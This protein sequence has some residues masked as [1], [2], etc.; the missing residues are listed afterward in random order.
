M[1]KDGIPVLFDEIEIGDKLVLRTLLN[2]CLY[3]SQ[4]KILSLD[5]IGEGKPLAKVTGTIIEPL[6]SPWKEKLMEILCTRP[7]S[8]ARD[9]SVGNTALLSD[10]D[11]DVLQVG[12]MVDA[13]CTKT[14]K[15]FEAKIIEIVKDKK[16]KNSSGLAQ[17]FKI[18]FKGWRARYDEWI[19]RGSD[20]LRTFG[21]VTKKIALR[22]ASVLIP[23]FES[24][25]LYEKVFFLSI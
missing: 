17:S 25:T 11:W 9:I 1:D 23:W 12:D 6:Q 16:S 21:I 5:D 15:W 19:P 8:V 22:K 13:Y 2:F 10:S 20:R 7:S 14:L 3:D 18:H 24:T 4:G